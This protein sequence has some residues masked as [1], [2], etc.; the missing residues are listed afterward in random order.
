MSRAAAK[1]TNTLAWF[2]VL[3]AGVVIVLVVWGLSLF[4]RLDAGQSVLD[5]ARPAFTE[6]RVAGDIAGVEMIDYIVNM[7]DPIVDAEG[8]AAGEVGPFVELVAGVTG[9]WRPM[10][11]W[12]WRRISLIRSICC[13]RCRLRM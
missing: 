12:R 9:L 10:F 3:V 4:S 7:A 8:G 2:V 13:C 11:W 5:G 1:N 6:E